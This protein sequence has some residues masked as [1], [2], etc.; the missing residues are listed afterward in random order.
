MVRSPLLGFHILDFQRQ[1]V[2]EEG[3]VTTCNAICE[4][5][6]Q[7]CLAIFAGEQV[8]DFYCDC[9]WIRCGLGPWLRGQWRR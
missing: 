2:V 8:E 6:A 5:L 7:V 4:E 9:F 1:L 3:A